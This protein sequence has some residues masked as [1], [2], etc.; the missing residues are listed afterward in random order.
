MQGINISSVKQFR[1]VILRQQSEK[2]QYNQIVNEW[3]IVFFITAGVYVSGAIV[4]WFLGSAEIQQ[5]GKYEQDDP[6]VGVKNAGVV[7][8]GCE[9]K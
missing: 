8:E 4:Y 5:W 3:R 1:R 2:S 9:S 6:N 7:N